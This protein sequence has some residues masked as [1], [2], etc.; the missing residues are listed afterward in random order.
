M[1][2]GHMPHPAFQV[3]PPEAGEVVYRFLEGPE[4]QPEDFLSDEADLRNRAM[5]ITEN[6]AIYRG[7]STRNTLTQAIRLGRLIRKRWVAEL[8]LDADEGDAIATTFPRS[9]GHRTV[10]AEAESAYRRVNTVHEIDD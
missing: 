9:R 7:F 2:P 10:W 1:L 4:P 3:R 8:R 5:V 6:V